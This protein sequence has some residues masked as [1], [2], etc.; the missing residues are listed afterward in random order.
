MLKLT[1]TTLRKIEDIFKEMDYTVRY[2]KG[3]FNSGYCIVEERN[4]V[5]INKFFDIEG[6]INCLLDI[7][8]SITINEAL[9]SNVNQS[10]YRLI[11][12]S[13]LMPSADMSLTI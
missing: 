5:I 11:Q 1:K 6:R 3:T 7:L 12:R 9:L 8:S 13:E 2:E 10:N 4:I